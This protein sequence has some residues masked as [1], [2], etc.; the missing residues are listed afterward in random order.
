MFTSLRKSLSW[1]SEKQ[2][3]NKSERKCQSES[4]L[5]EVYLDPKKRV[6]S[7]DS[8]QSEH[9][10]S[11]QSKK[12]KIERQE[13]IESAYLGPSSALTDTDVLPNDTPAWGVKLLEIMQ[14]EFRQVAIHMKVVEDQSDQNEKDIHEMEQK[15]CK[16]ENKNKFLQEEN[17][18]LK[19]R[20]LDLEY[21]QRQCNLIFEG[22][23]DNAN[24]T[25]VDCI[26][27]IRHVLSGIHNLNARAIVVDNCFRLD[28]PFRPNRC[29][30][31]LCTLNWYHDVQVILR[32]RKQLPTGVFV[33][34][35][36][37]EEWVDRHKI[38]H[39]IVVAAKR[40][41]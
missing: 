11:S 35:D 19:E 18:T 29:R 1:E 6:R 13:A 34:E 9:S 39:P 36:L 2:K 15:L 10:G 32:N 24:E 37:P 3:D 26:G 12:T 17:V 40:N 14:K 4:G 30:R 31:I 7:G 21:K 38:L 27:K 5:E 41:E 16:T 22:V 25:D 20:L 28:G 23:V 8:N 33:N